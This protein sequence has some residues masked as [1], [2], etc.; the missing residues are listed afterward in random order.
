VQPDSIIPGLDNSNGPANPDAWNRYEYANNNSIRYNDPTGHDVGCAGSDADNCSDNNVPQD[1]AGYDPDI[2]IPA[3]SYHPDSI[4][5]S[6]NLST[7]IAPPDFK[8]PLPNGHPAPPHVN[9]LPDDK[10]NWN[11][12]WPDTGPGYQNEEDPK[13]IVYRPDEGYTSKTG[14]EGEQPH[15]N[16]KEPG[17]K[18]DG[19]D[20]PP[21]PKWGRDGQRKNPGDFNPDTG[22]YGSSSSSLFSFGIFVGAPTAGYFIYRGVRVILSPACGGLAPVCAFAGP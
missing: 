13:G 3:Y 12:H 15:W 21:N 14:Q 17:E 18:G 7:F 2:F 6:S 4:L 16:A 9:G 10:Y 8:N 19:T 20:F 22:L 11:N 1:R 5:S